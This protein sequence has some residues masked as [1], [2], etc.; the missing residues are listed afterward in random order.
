M[1]RAFDERLYVLK[2][3]EPCLRMHRETESRR[4]RVGFEERKLSQGLGTGFLGK[5]VD[6]D[7][8][9]VR[10]FL[11]DV[12]K[13]CR[14]VRLSEGEIITSDF[15]R[16]ELVPRVFKAIGASEGSMRWNIDLLARRTGIGSTDV[17]PALHHLAWEIGHVKSDLANR[18][19]IEASTLAKQESRNARVVPNLPAVGAA[20][21]PKESETN[22]EQVANVN[23]KPSAGLIVAAV[24]GFWGAGLTVIVAQGQSSWLPHNHWLA[25]ALFSI[26]A[27]LVVWTILA[28]R[29]SHGS[30][31][32]EISYHGE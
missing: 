8:S 26:P 9:V 27:A 21:S 16:Q 25:P 1:R 11:E 12:D 32:I 7:I 3:R 2:L 5:Q 4:R 22:H 14:E 17:T 18:Y 31:R 24:F 15:I 10:E 29:K 28:R 20:P 6:S 30:G 23:W 13:V 19:E